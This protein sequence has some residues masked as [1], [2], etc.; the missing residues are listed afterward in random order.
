MVENLL[1]VLND[2]GEEWHAFI[3]LSTGPCSLFLA[4]ITWAV[5]LSLQLTGVLRVQWPLLFFVFARFKYRLE[6]LPRSPLPA[7]ER[8]QIRLEVTSLHD[9]STPTAAP[10]QAEGRVVSAPPAAPL[11][12][13]DAGAWTWCT[14]AEQELL[15]PRREGAGS[16]LDT[17]LRPVAEK[18]RERNGNAL[19][20]SLR[21][22][23]EQF[24]HQIELLKISVWEGGGLL[25]IACSVLREKP[26]CRCCGFQFQ[27]IF[28]PAFSKPCTVHC[29]IQIQS[30][31][32]HCPAYCLT[33]SSGRER[34]ILPLLV[35]LDT[36]YFCVA[37]V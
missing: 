6:L 7:F 16:S 27:Q 18:P 8:G 30:V 12:A 20:P 29:W 35:C 31:V 14:T 32:H 4:S 34:N 10:Q 37:S 22:I 13:V 19:F 36:A 15:P 9:T 23:Y 24:C 2:Q 17:P 21:D 11:R 3:L 1:T 25:N 33:S 26:N 28:S 5:C